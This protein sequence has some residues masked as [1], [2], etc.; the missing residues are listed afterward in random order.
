M[1]FPVCRERIDRAKTHRKT[2][3]QTWSDFLDTDPYET[4]VFV[5]SEGRGAIWVQPTHALPASLSLE[6]GEMLYQLRASLDGCIYT[7]A[8]IESGQEP[9]PDESALEFPICST[10]GAFKKSGRKI[11]ALANQQ[12]RRF[13]HSVQPCNASTLRAPGA[14][15]LPVTLGLLNDWARRDRHRRLNVIGS[16]PSQAEPKL[17]LPEGVTMRFFEIVGL[18]LLLD[19][20]TNIATFA[21]E[22]W[23]PQMDLQGNPDCV[24]DVASHEPPPP[25]DGSDTLDMRTQQMVAAVE[26]VVT[27]FEQAY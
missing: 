17:L 12:V 24:I 19:K 6:L 8:V 5:D 16:L 1:S 13:I 26:Y 10:A 22:G 14:S 27:A 25:R 20:Q 4:G 2:F 21:L 11:A 18:G 7:A 23:E 15:W 3:R 9:P